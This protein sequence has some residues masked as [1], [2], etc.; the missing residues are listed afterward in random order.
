MNIFQRDFLERAS[1]E[2]AKAGHPFPR[3]AACEAALESNYGNSALA[4]D[5]R[6]LFGMKQHAHPIFGTMNLPTREFVGEAKEK[7]VLDEGQSFDGKLDGWITVTAKWVEYP[8]FASCFADRK[9]TLERL[10]NVYP[11]YAAALRAAD[12]QNYIAEVSKTWSTDPDRACKVMSI[13]V[14]FAGLAGQ[15]GY[16]N[17]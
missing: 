5:G 10:A 9:A 14:D 1:A 6:N 12:A 13:Y 11:H 2:A 16:S 3:M 17:G 7:I 4:R 8:D 15:G